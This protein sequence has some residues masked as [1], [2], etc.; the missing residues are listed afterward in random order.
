MKIVV[1][2]DEEFNT[3]YHKCIRSIG[4]PVDPTP[5]YIITRAQDGATQFTY[6]RFAIPLIYNGWVIFCD[7]DFI[8]LEDI[9]K[10]YD[11][12]DDKYAVMVCKHPDYKPNSSIKMN[13]KKQSE[14]HRKNWSSLILWNCD[15]AANKVLTEDVINNIEPSYL[16][17]FKW[18]SDNLIGSIP[19]EWNTLVGYYH[20]ENPKALHYTD[21]TPDIIGKTEY[22]E[23]YWNDEI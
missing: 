13:N 1:G 19:L 11:L 21:G 2:Y 5:N 23:E 14:Y 8:F 12:R 3:S 7:S 6:S 16:H 9:K 18:L 17:Q 20:F 15:H 10:L 22:E 4:Y